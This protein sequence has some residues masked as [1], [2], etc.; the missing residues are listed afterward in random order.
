MAKTKKVK[1]SKATYVT[2]ARRT[3]GASRTN[4]ARGAKS[5]A[6]EKIEL[7]ERRVLG[8]YIVADPKICHGKVTFI[9]TRI[10]VS[11]V[12]EM[13]AEARAW[14]DIIRQC[15]G[16]ISNEAITEAVQLAHEAFLK[17]IDKPDSEPL[18]L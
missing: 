6:K 9:G 7:P 8:K 10:F 1:E 14:D 4:G 3:N 13:V 5:R 18:S 2:R 11:D 15:H 16:S 12:I 17:Y